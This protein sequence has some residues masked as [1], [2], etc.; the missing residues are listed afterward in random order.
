MTGG[1]GAEPFTRAAANLPAEVIAQ[2]LAAVDRGSMSVVQF[3]A[4]LA[5]ATVDESIFERALLEL[6]R[7]PNLDAIRLCD[8]VYRLLAGRLVEAHPR[9]LP[10]SCRLWAETAAVALLLLLLAAA[11][12]RFS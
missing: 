12:I 1:A 9:E 5:T 4:I 6:Q 8:T 2:L 3:N 7:D 11:I 10:Q